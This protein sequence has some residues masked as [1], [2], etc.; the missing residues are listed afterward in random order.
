[1]MKLRWIL[2]LV[3]LFL[4]APLA[5]QG[6]PMKE[7]RQMLQRQIGERF[8]QTVATQLRLDPE[9]RTQ[10]QQQLLQSGERRR[11][12]AERSQILRLQMVRAARDS[13]TSDAEL[14]KFLN[15]AT[16]LKERE[17]E[18]WKGDQAALSRILTPRQHVHFM[19]MWLRFNDQIRDVTN[20]QARPPFDR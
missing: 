9:T 10:L 13:T 17:D 8:M 2:L 12:L 16:A 4:P 19:F 15:E 18:L 5:A 1:M 20:R 11:D 6:P 14:R 3:T 7:R